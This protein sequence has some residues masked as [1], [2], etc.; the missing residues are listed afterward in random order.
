MYVN[1]HGKFEEKFNGPE[2][3]VLNDE[4]A[5]KDVV[6]WLRNVDRKPWALCV[7]Y[8]VD[9][10]WRPMYPDFLVIRNEKGV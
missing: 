6:A 5:R 3:A 9:G 1:D 7:P 8:E 10:E 2:T 4:I